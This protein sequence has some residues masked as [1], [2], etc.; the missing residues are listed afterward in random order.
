MTDKGRYVHGTQPDEQSRLSR[1]NELLNQASLRELNPAPG[2]RVV[3]VGCGLA[4][5]TRAIA[6][7]TGATGYTLGIER[8]AEQLAEARRQAV[9]AGEER[10]VEFRHAEI[11]PLPLTDSEWSSFDVAHARFVL[12][13]VPDPLTIVKEMVGA[14]RPGGRIV[15][16]DDHHDTMRLTPEC[17]EF[18]PL[19]DAYMKSYAALGNDPHVGHRLVTLLHQAGAKPVRNTWIFFGACAGD[20]MLEPYVDNLIGILQTARPTMIASSLIDSA[21]YAAGLDALRAWVKRPDAAMW[22]AISWA[23]GTR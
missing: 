17:P 23:E 15:L 21:S 18:P 16:E 2:D 12:E 14:V 6:R 8:S 1:L 9:A 4:Q 7:T 10:L 11:P 22:F 13:H 20:S 19:W 3:D 5:L